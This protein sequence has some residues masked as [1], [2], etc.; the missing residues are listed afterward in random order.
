[1]SVSFE[2]S[3]FFFFSTCY[4]YYYNDYF[5]KSRCWLLTYIIYSIFEDTF[6]GLSNLEL[7]MNPFM[8]QIHVY[9]S[10]LSFILYI[11]LFHYY[12]YYNYLCLCVLYVY[13]PCWETYK[14][15]SRF[16]SCFVL[17]FSN[18]LFLYCS[19][20]SPCKFEV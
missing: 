15:F 2:I 8:P 13:R 18:F 6:F 20:V 4:C 3:F 17:L 16:K 9:F 7:F 19:I 14:I 10:F 1:M 12:Y 11:Y 5:I